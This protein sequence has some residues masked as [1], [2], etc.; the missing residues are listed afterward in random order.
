MWVPCVALVSVGTISG[1]GEYGYHLVSVD[2]TY[3]LGE[4]WVLCV[5]LAGA[6]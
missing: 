5:A 3:G 6:V 1:L 4:V 2:T